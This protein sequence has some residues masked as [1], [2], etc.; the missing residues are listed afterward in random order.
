[1]SE[2]TKIYD[3]KE[4]TFQ[5]SV[6]II[7]LF[8]SLDIKRT[9]NYIIGKQLLRSAT[10]ISAMCEEAVSGESNADF[11]HKYSVALK[12]ARETHH[13]LRLLVATQMIT[14]EK[15]KEI[16]QEANEIKKIIGA[17]VVNLKK[18]NN[19]KN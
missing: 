3:I 19:A 1:M 16:V 10:S 17:I 11:I 8:R 12:E 15:A 18:K 4:R 2:E 5:F 13:W 6:Q 14:D 7:S 9:E